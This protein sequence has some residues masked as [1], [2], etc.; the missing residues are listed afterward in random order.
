MQKHK[1]N[2]ATAV[3]IIAL[4]VFTAINGCKKDAAEACNNGI[5]DAGERGVDCGSSCSACTATQYR[6]RTAEIPGF[7]FTYFY[8]Q[9]GRLD[10]VFTISGGVGRFGSTYTYS[11]NKVVRNLFGG[12]V[13]YQ[14]NNEGYAESC[15]TNI[16]GNRVDTTY[17]TYDV[18]GHLLTGSVHELTWQNGNMITKDGITYSY[19]ND[20][21]NTIGNENSG[22]SFL[23]RSSTFLPISESDSHLP[24]NTTIY[25]Y[26]YDGLG[27]VI[28]KSYGS[29][30]ETYTYY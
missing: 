16:P 1:T 8:D 3:T 20:K 13:T 27:R 14:L 18:E 12:T 19:F 11:G 30:R 23:G 22:C 9:Q 17:Y 25:S 7:S 6:L 5:M 21:F 4:F 28:K 15:I 2:L 10:S 29:Q 26:V 24:A